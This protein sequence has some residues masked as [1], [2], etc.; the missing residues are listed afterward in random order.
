MEIALDLYQIYMTKKAC[1]AEIEVNM[2]MIRSKNEFKQ[3]IL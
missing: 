1:A 2:P 3:E